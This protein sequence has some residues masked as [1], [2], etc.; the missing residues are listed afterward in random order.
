MSALLTRVHVSGPTSRAHLTA[1]LGL[2]RSTIGDL[3]TQ[4]AA[5]GLVR[6]EVPTGGRRSGRPSLVV[7][8]RADVTVLAIGLDVD[9]IAVALV[10]L[11]GQVLDR[12]TRVHQRGEHDVAQVVE[13]VA[14]MARDILGGSLAGRCVAAGT[15]APGAVRA[16]DGLVRFAPNLGWVDAPFTEMLAD[17]LQM[18]VTTD[19]DANLGVLAEHLRGAAVGYNDVGY[20]SGSVGIGGGFLLSGTQLRG[21]QGYAGEVGHIPVDP[22]GPECRCGA[23][24]CW[25]TKVG[26]NQ[27]LVGAGRL[28]GGGPEAVEEVIRAAG[29]GDKRAAS[30]L[31][32]TAH[33]IGIGLRTVVHLFNPQVVLLGGVLAMVWQSRREVVEGGLLRGVLVPPSQDVEIRPA[34]LGPDSSLMGAAELAFAPLLADPLGWT[35]GA[36][37]LGSTS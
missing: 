21:S 16:S 8:P 22:A 19:N 23:Y 7:V 6:E 13:S 31:E 10:G 29:S 34:G 11:G 15:S 27:L 26:E 17:E 36:T 4:L 18:P 37:V 28:P 2:N 25:E 14:Q 32:E 33:W 35:A 24:G 5:L 12:R 1:E 30:A 20:L 9:R 3:T